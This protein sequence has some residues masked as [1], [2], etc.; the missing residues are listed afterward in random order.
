MQLL[1][2]SHEENIAG[3]RVLIT[4]D[5]LASILGCAL[6]DAK[7]RFQGRQ[8]WKVSERSALLQYLAERRVH[9]AAT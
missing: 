9:L 3:W 8:T 7:K 1:D 2:P 5:E 6:K 4:A